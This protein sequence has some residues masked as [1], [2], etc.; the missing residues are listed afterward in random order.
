MID[1]L[2]ISH[3]NVRAFND[4]VKQNALLKRVGYEYDI[5][6]LAETHSSPRTEA[7]VKKS[8]PHLEFYFNHGPEFKER[9][10]GRRNDKEQAKGTLIVFSSNLAKVSSFK[11]LIQGQLSCLDMQI[12]SKNFRIT[13]VYAPAEAETTARLDFFRQVFNPITLDPDKLNIIPGDWNCG[14][15]MLDHHEYANWEL[16]R[17]RTRK[18][19]LDGILENYLCDPYRIIHEVERISQNEGWSWKDSKDPRNASPDPNERDK[20]KKSRIDYILVSEALVDFINHAGISNPPFEKGTDH[21]MV[22]INI[23]FNSTRP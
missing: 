2:R 12:G 20:I 14:L 4:T 17:P 22:N 3:L 7:V 10:D 23:Q 1:N 11:V 16:H 5:L 21:R 6:H 19:I 15:S 9:S 8:Y 18:F 13:S